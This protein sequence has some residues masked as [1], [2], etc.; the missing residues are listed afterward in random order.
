MLI[1]LVIMDLPALFLG[2][3]VVGLRGGLVIIIAN[4]IVF[5][6]IQSVYLVL[7]QTAWILAFSELVKPQKLEQEEVVPVPE[8]IS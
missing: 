3:I 5:I 7:Q 2:Q 8:V 4:G 1:L 6:L